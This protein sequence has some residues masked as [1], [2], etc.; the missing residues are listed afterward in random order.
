MQKTLLRLEMEKMRKAA[1]KDIGATDIPSLATGLIQAGVL[2]P[3]Q[4]SSLESIMSSKH[5]HEA[6]VHT[7]ISNYEINRVCCIQACLPQRLLVLAYQSFVTTA[8]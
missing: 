1:G 2:S 4:Q 8:E 5:R 3:K 6:K 7:D